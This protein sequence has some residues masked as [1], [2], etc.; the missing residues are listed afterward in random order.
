MAAGY[1]GLQVVSE[2]DA[3]SHQICRWRFSDDDKLEIFS[4]PNVPCEDR[5]N[6]DGSLVMKCDINDNIISTT[7]TIVIPLQTTV[8]IKI[9]CLETVISSPLD[10][11][12]LDLGVAGEQSIN[13]LEKYRKIIE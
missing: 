6:V 11:V 4:Q 8:V 9:V 10:V 7:I 3:S 13:V 2:F 12:T 1:S 5:S